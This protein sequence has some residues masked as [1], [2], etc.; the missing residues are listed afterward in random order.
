MSQ[1]DLSGPSDSGPASP[2]SDVADPIR[3]VGGPW[4]EVDTA[5]G[6]ERVRGREAAEA[7]LEVEPDESYDVTTVDRERR[8]ERFRG[9]AFKFELSDDPD[10]DSVRVERHDGNTPYVNVDG[11]KVTRHAGH[12]GRGR[13]TVTYQPL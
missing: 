10:P 1:A 6:P 5:D 13:W 8:L 2:G 3:H 4:F 12:F 11:R 7:L 9:P